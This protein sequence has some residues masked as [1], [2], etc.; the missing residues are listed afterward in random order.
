MAAVLRYAPW[1]THTKDRPENYLHD[2]VSAGRMSARAAQL[3]MREN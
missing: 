3:E 2:E 1:N